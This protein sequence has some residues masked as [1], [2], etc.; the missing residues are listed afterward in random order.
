MTNMLMT[1]VMVAYAVLCA[2]FVAAGIVILHHV[3][4]KWGTERAVES[5]KTKV[6]PEVEAMTTRMFN[7]M[8][9]QTMDKTVKMV[10]KMTEEAKKQYDY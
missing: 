10:E 5:M 6:L 3:L 4:K 1:M 9:D 8:V 2:G 7:N